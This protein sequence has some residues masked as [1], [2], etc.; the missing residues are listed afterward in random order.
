VLV[1]GDS[2]GKPEADLVLRGLDGVGA[3][4]DVAAELDAEIASDGAGL[5]G[6]VGWR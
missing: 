3:V 5:G 1:V 6:A 4:D 2:L